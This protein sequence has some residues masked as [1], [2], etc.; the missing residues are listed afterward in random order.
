MRIVR[1]EI[2]GPVGA[3]MTFTDIDDAI[4]KANDTEYGLA[5]SVWTTD[6]TNAHRM[7]AAVQAGTV[8]INTWGEMSTGNLPF[9][10]YKQSGLGREGGLE[11]LDAYTQSKAVVVAL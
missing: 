1:E 2:F 9:G 4:A 10:G 7:A 8:W 5:A 6:L 11:V 3:L